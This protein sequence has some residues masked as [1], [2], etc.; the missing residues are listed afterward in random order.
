M[1]N[2]GAKPKAVVLNHGSY[3]A[4]HNVPT[5]PS[6]LPPAPAQKS[7]AKAAAANAP[8]GIRQ[9]NVVQATN[10]L[11]GDIADDL[12]GWAA[13]PPT[14]KDARSSKASG[15]APSTN[16]GKASTPVVPDR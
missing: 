11:A 14:A 1:G 2:K 3:P 6:S 7:T 9:G 4:K 16:Q 8:T 12:S 13:D 5:P 15:F 10:D